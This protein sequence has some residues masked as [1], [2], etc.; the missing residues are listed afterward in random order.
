MAFPELF[1]ILFHILYA[2]SLLKALF[3][4][5]LEWVKWLVSNMA[6]WEIPSKWKSLARKI[7]QKWY[8]GFSSKPYLITGGWYWVRY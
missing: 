1:K 2:H 5:A 4:W 8:G 6:S 7:I 3:R